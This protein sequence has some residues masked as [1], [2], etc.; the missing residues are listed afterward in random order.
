MSW[1]TPSRPDGHW[2]ALSDGVFTRALGTS[3]AAFYWD[4]EAAGTA[5][6]SERTRIRIA[7]PERRVADAKADEERFRDIWIVVK[8]RFPLLGARVKEEDRGLTLKFVIEEA[9][10]QTIGGHDEFEFIAD[11]DIAASDAALEQAVNGRPRRISRNTLVGITILRRTDLAEGTYDL[12]TVGAHLVVDGI[13]SCTLARVFSDTLARWPS[14]LETSVVELPKRLE[15]LLSSESLH[16]QLRL[17]LSRQRWRQAIAG[18][19]F[20]RRA[21]L[22]ANGHTLPRSWNSQSP[23]A[24]AQSSVARL[25]FAPEVT[26]KALASCRAHGVTLGNILYALSQVALSRLLHRRIKR[27]EMPLEEWAARLRVPMHTGGPLN[28]RPFLVPDWQEAGGHSEINLSVGFFVM[29]LPLPPLTPPSPLAQTPPPSKQTPLTLR[30]SPP[31]SPARD[32]GTAPRSQNSARSHHTA[33]RSTSSSSTR[34]IPSAS[35]GG[36][37]LPKRGGGFRTGRRSRPYP[38]RPPTPWYLRISARVWGMYMD[39]ILP[40]SYPLPSAQDPTPKIIVERVASDLHLR[41][42]PGELYFGAKTSRGV[43]EFWVFYDANTYQKTVVEEW[44]DEIK[45]AFEYYLVEED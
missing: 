40:P 43:T 15:M 14:S 6:V 20:V 34:T 36:A 3:E 7:A 31:F 18:V 30:R 39:H 33:T 8:K 28:L 11:A 23:R 12:V 32:S 21:K 38:N 22:L 16:T 24:P 13:A 37:A 41:C 45:G 17:S 29:S 19:I 25:W 10:L 35:R 44:L 9:K 4:G 42:R 5:D 27:G 1:T 26:P 2:K